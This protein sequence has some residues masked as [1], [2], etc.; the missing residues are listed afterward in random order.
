MCVY[1]YI[2]VYRGIDENE[3]EREKR[4]SA[5]TGKY[6]LSNFEWSFFFFFTTL[7]I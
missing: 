4:G 1:I 5:F 7:P 3:R 2:Y 6:Y